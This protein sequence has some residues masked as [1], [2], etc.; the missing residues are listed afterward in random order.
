[1]VTDKSIRFKK[2]RQRGSLDN[3]AIKLFGTDLH[4]AHPN[5]RDNPQSGSIFQP[6][7]LPTKSTYAFVVKNYQAI[8]GGVNKDGSGQFTSKSVDITVLTVST[9]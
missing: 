3:V 1:M 6:W 5:T 9:K 2:T 7:F 8:D 4:N